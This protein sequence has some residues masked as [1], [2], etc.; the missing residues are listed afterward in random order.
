VTAAHPKLRVEYVAAR[1]VLLDALEALGVQSRAVIVAG[2]QAIYFRTGPDSL[3]I[4]EFTIDGDLAVDPR[5]LSDA[6]L[7]AELMEAADFRLAVL[8]GAKEPGIWEK[9]TTIEGQD[10]KVPVDLIVPSAVAP[11]GGTRGARLVP[12]GKRAARKASGLEAALT[13]NDVIEI[14]SLE[15][16]DSRNAKIRV[17]GVAALLIAKAHKIADRVASGREDRLDD[18]DATDVLRLMT[19][20]DPA[21]IAKTLALLRAHDVCGE[22]ARTAIDLIQDLFGN[23]AGAGIAMAA[24]SL[25]EAMPEERVRVI[26]LSYTEALREAL[27]SRP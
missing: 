25:E 26:C 17:A 1:R 3:P 16:S 21:E 15:E 10:I 8:Q 22:T 23:R 9:V 12:H 2:A 18:K 7:I 4:T 5:Q 6:P 11:P 19:S 20:S 14:V 24:R 27:S 13:D